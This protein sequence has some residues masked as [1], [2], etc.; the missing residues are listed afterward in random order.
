MISKKNC[1]SREYIFLIHSQD[2]SRSSFRFRK[3]V[4]RH[5]LSTVSSS[6]RRFDRFR[7]KLRDCTLLQSLQ[8]AFLLKVTFLHSVHRIVPFINM[9]LNVCLKC[10]SVDQV[11]LC[12]SMPGHRSSITIEIGR[13]L[14][15]PVQS[16]TMMQLSY[17]PR[18]MY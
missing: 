9:S 4:L 14:F 1:F 10:G 5:F 13:I 15:F 3:S 16:F 2:F 12:S 18:Q 7:G 6:A 8:I 17:N 11:S